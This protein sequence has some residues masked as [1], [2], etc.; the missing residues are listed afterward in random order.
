[1]EKVE[2]A[3][4]K[5]ISSNRISTSEVSD[6]LGKTG[7]LRKVLP[8]N[9][10][11]FRVGRVRFAYAYKCSNWE[12][13]EQLQDVQPGDVVVVEAIGCEDYAVFGQLV[14]K[15]LMLYRSA[16][17]IVV[18]GL[19]RDYG[20]LRQWNWPVWSNGYTPIGCY[21][22]K[23]ETL[24]DT[25]MLAEIRG[26]YEGAIAVCDDG[27]IVIIPKESVN[28]EFLDKLD[29][30][31]IQEDAWF[32]SI[33]VDKFTTYETVCLKK[34]LSEGSMFSKYDKLKKDLGSA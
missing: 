1:M 32:H 16:S 22:R 26:R 24:P 4:I 21:N 31:E 20:E 34:Y 18:N 3:I 23:N 7:V 5:K 6:C 19:L 28:E 9:F 14:T 2:E 13:H 27:G 17:A 10:G 25:E 30:I 8:L 33:D 12:L 29:I 15:F 11:H